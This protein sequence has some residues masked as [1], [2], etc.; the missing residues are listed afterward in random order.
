MNLLDLVLIVLVVMFAV[1][2]YRQ[3]FAVGALSFVGFLGGGV[4][5]AKVAR[6]FAELIG[7]EEDGALVGLIVVVGLALVGQ[8]AGTALGAALRGRLT[9]RPGQRL[10]AVAGAVLSGVSV[11]LVAWLVATAVDRSPFQTLARAAR[12][13]EVLGTVDTTMPDD[14]RHTF[15][16]LRRLMDDQGF[17]EVFAG[18]DGERI[19]ATDPPDPA[20][21]SAAD[22]QNA[23]ASILKVRGQA[24]SCGKQV[25]GTGFVIAPQRVMTNAHVVAGVTEAVVELDSGAL[26][27]EVVLFDPDRDVAVLHVP[28]LLRPPLRFQSAPPG[29]MGDSAV[30][31][32]YPQDGPYTTEPARIRNEQVARAP[33]I[34]SRGTVRREIYAIRGRV[35]PGNSGGPLL[36]SA[37]TVYGVVFAAATDDNDTGYVLTADEVSEPVRQGA[38]ALVPVSTQSCD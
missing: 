24:P 23:A 38:Q 32:G 20:V 2:G 17:P 28:G 12:G 11:L 36:S 14:V 21:V 3:G 35:R 13:S 9:W 30:V 22:V 8:I 31:A 5:G 15:A 18:L 27:A 34:Y 25:E 1:S 19:V 26:P 4:L 10:D 16:D 37:G 29:D 33:D 7:R 6:P